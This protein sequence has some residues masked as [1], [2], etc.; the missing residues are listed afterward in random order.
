M[1]GNV[2]GAI[3]FAIVTTFRYLQARSL[4]APIGF[5]VVLNGMAVLGGLPLQAGFEGIGVG[6]EQTIGVV[7]L[8]VAIPLLAGYLWWQASSLYDPLPYVENM[9]AERLVPPSKTAS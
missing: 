3:L 1:H 2:V 5:H 7:C 9:V 4:W 8:V 6:G